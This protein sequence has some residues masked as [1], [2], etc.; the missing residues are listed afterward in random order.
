MGERGLDPRSGWASEA[1][2]FLVA[3]ELLRRDKYGAIVLSVAGTYTLR[4][5]Y[6]LFRGAI[7]CLFL[8]SL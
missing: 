2:H 7:C 1:V 8:H 6:C 5:V 3:A 4:V